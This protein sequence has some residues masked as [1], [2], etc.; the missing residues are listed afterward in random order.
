[1]AATV[2]SNQKL[3]A[4]SI[5]DHNCIFELSVIERKGNWA[6]INYEGNVRRVKVYTGAD[7]DEY[8]RPEKYSMAPIFRAIN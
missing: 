1:M 7:G 4:R 6:T 5:C 3:T 8:L 2:K